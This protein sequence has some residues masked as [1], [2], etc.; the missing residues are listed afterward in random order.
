MAEAASLRTAWLSTFTEMNM[1]FD[2]KKPIKHDPYAR[3]GY[4]TEEDDSLDDDPFKE[5]RTTQPLYNVVT[6]TGF[7]RGRAVGSAA[8]NTEFQNPVAHMAKEGMWNFELAG[9][10]DRLLLMCHD[11]VDYWLWP[12]EVKQI[13][14]LVEQLWL[15]P[16]QRVLPHVKLKC[17]TTLSLYW[18]KAGVEFGDVE[19]DA[20]GCPILE[21]PDF[22]KKAKGEL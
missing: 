8:C 4:N 9:L 19:W 1:H 7:R 3:Y 20:N 22:V 16:G 21:V 5:K 15:E 18:D 17:E 11:E 12:H 6:T 2:S 14:P 10:G 13:V